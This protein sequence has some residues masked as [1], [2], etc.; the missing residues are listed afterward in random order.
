M[1][2]VDFGAEKGTVALVCKSGHGS[3]NYIEDPVGC[4]LVIPYIMLLY[5]CSQLVEG[6]DTYSIDTSIPSLAFGAQHP[7]RRKYFSVKT[8]SQY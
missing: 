4:M 8:P 1:P 2:R 5:F 7:N 6:G 3:G